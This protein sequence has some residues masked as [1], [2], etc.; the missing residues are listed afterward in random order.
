[1]FK[2]NARTCHSHR[3][4]CSAVVPWHRPQVH[5]FTFEYSIVCMP[6]APAAAPSGLATVARKRK[7]LFSSAHVL[8]SRAVLY[9]FRTLLLYLFRTLFYPCAR[10]RQRTSLS[11]RKKGGL[12][13]TSLTNGRSEGRLRGSS[14]QSPSHINPKMVISVLGGKDVSNF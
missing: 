9:L 10:T 4:T 7:C 2:D 13:G 5:G 1:M 14:R 6:I 11:L 8:K 3:H 12:H